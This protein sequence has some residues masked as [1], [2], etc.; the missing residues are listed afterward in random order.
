MTNLLKTLTTIYP[1][2]TQRV[3]DLQHAIDYRFREIDNLLEA[4]THSSAARSL[5]KKPSTKQPIP[6]NE[7]LEFL[8]DSVLG[9]AISSWLINHPERYPEGDL[10]RMRS[11]L[12]NEQTLAEIAKEHNLGHCLVLSKGEDNNGGRNKP[13]VTADAVEALI[14]AIYLDGGMDC[15]QRFIEKIFCKYLSQDINN[16][17]GCDYKTQ[18][19]ELTQSISKITPDYR[20]IE[21]IG[22]D[23]AASFKVT[24]TFQ[25]R[26]LGVGTGR[27]KKSASQQAA[28][29]ALEKFGE[30]EILKLSTESGRD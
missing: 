8:G 2:L 9:L 21:K 14:G 26:E 7:R 30:T 20:V 17:K 11:S 18:L 10:S 28:F 24:V 12:V 25:G 16:L 6:W 1:D 13:S 22:P 4:I 27:T 23:H 19:Q 3:E 29:A 5:M 15:A